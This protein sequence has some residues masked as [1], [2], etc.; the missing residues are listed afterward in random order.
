MIGSV[1]V[2]L[3][4]ALGNRIKNKPLAFIAGFASHLLGDAVPHYDMG[5]TELPL[6]FGTLAFIIQKHGWNS[7][8]FFG[9]AGAVLPDLEHIPAELR[10]DP[11]RHEPMDEKLFPTHNNRVPHGKWP[12]GQEPF[13]IL[14]NIVLY[15]GGLYLAGLLER[16][17]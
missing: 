13:G 12:L 6:M 3:G 15:L 9:A 8:Q 14:M 17:K 10:K 2:A 16:S 5:L 11:R 4:A 1:H 7:P